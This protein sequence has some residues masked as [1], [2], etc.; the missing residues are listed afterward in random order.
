MVGLIIAPCTP[1]Y[2]TELKVGEGDGHS[3][4]KNL[5]ELRSLKE[6]VAAWHLSVSETRERHKRDGFL[7]WD[8]DEPDAM[9]FVSAA[10]NIRAAIFQ[11]DQKTPW[12]VKEMAGNII[13]GKMIRGE[14]ISGHEFRFLRPR[15]PRI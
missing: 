15:K 3:T 14:F 13:P 4:G 9:M 7:E 1:N 5:M 6:N 8:K 12:K 10:A 11:I 2:N